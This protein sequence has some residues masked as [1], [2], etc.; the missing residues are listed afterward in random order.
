MGCIE[1][2][3]YKTTLF[4]QTSEILNKNNTQTH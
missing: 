2:Q 3:I 4:R 1:G